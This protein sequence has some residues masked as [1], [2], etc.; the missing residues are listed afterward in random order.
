MI[1]SRWPIV[2]SEVIGHWSLGIG[3]VFYTVIGLLVYWCI[4]EMIFAGTTS[5][6]YGNVLY[7]NTQKFSIFHLPSSILPWDSNPTLHNS[8]FL[9]TSYSLLIS[10]IRFLTPHFFPKEKPCLIS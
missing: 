8:R 3:G 9:V 2:D 4:G 5:R 6:F 1:D 7:R 10:T